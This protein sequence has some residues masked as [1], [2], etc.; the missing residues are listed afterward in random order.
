MKKKQTLRRNAIQDVCTAIQTQRLDN[1]DTAWCGG[2]TTIHS[3]LG[4]GTLISN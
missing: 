1:T 2:D 3:T 4:D